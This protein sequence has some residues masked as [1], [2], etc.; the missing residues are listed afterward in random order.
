MI[1]K[2]RHLGGANLNRVTL[3][4][5]IDKPLDPVDVSLLGAVAVVAPPHGIAHLVK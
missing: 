3:R 2:S 5:K 4:R 1:E